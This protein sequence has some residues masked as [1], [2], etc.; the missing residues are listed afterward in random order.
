MPKLR[1]CGAWLAVALA[2][3]VAVPASGAAERCKPLAVDAEGDTDRFLPGS[4]PESDLLAMDART[5]P[6]AR[7]VSVTLSLRSLPGTALTGSGYDVFFKSGQRSYLASAYRGPDGERFRLESDAA[8]GQ[9]ADVRPINGRFDVKAATVR[10]D[11]PVT[12]LTDGKSPLRRGSVLYGITGVTSELYGI[13]QAHIGTTA[14]ST[15]GDN[16]YRIGAGCPRT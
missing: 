11:L 4:R 12:G 6:D 8:Q 9:I 2:V 14:D 16:I 15:T 5:S 7:I 13:A 10:F 3:A 1:R